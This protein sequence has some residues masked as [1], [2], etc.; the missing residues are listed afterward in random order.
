[1]KNKIIQCFKNKPKSTEKS[2][3][4]TSWHGVY[5]FTS[6]NNL[7]KIFGEPK[8]GDHKTNYN[9]YCETSKGKVFTIYDWKQ[10]R[11]VSLDEKVKY[12]IGGF[13]KEGTE[14]AKIEIEKIFLLESFKNND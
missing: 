4:Y 8:K 13:N 12:H 5:I 2:V 7:I 14:Q 9:W 11:R 3:N 6:A 10:Y 1:M